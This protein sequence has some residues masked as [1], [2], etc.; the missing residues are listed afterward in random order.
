MMY[1]KYST[2]IVLVQRRA[3]DTAKNPI[4]YFMLATSGSFCII[5]EC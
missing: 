4:C 2:V 3:C 1:N 5:D